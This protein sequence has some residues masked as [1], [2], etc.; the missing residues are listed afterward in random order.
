MAAALGQWTVTTYFGSNHV[1][2]TRRLASLLLGTMAGQ[3]SRPDPL[4]AAL[5]RPGGIPLGNFY[6]FLTSADVA[7]LTQ[8]PREEVPG[9]AIHDHVLFD[10]DFRAP[11]NQQKTLPLGNILQNGRNTHNTFNIGLDALTKHVVVIGVTGSGKTTTVMNLLDRV[12]E[13]GRPFLVIEPAKTEY[14]A[15]RAALADRINLRIYTLGSEMVAPFRLNPF[16]FQTDD[17]PGAV[18][19]LSHIDFLK[20]VFNAAFESW[21]PLPQVLEEAMHEIYEDKGWD[22]ASGTNRRVPDWS[23]RHDYPIF[24]SMTDLYYK[25]QIVADR[26]GYKGEVEGNVKAALKARIGSLRIGSKGLMLD[27][28]RG[29]PM[30]ELLAH[31]TILELENIG[32]DD[33]KTFIMGIL[34]ARLYEF[35]R[36]EAARV[37]SGHLSSGMRHLLV[38]EEAHR[39][40]KNTNTQVATDS[41]NPRAQAIEVFTNMLSEVRAY[42]QGVL[43][44]EQIPS[45][46]APDVL[47]NTN[48]KIVHRLIAQDDRQ[49]IGQTMNL[50]EAQQMH[51]GILEPGMAEVYAEGADH[52]YL[53]RMEN[54]KRR[55]APLTDNELKQISREYASTRPY[56]LILEMHEYDLPKSANGDIDPTV[57]LIA[58][59]LLTFEMSRRIWARL[60]FCLVMRPTNVPGLLH[61]CS[62][63]I[64]EEMSYLTPEQHDAILRM[65][66]VRGCAEVLHERGSRF[67]WT[68]SQVE[69]LRLPLTRGLLGLAY[70]EELKRAN[71]ESKRDEMLKVLDKSAE[72]LM[73]FVN[74]YTTFMERRQGPFPGCIHCPVKCLYRSEVSS[75]LMPKDRQWIN[76]ELNSQAHKGSKERYGAVAQAARHIAQT[77]LGEE[78]GSTPGFGVSSIAYCTVLHTARFFQ[79]T[80]Y[81]QGMVGDSLKPFLLDE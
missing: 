58:G 28:A 8:L 29:V 65:L 78:L 43:V 6:S 64:E 63:M 48:L 31:P 46:L 54:Y 35:R 70:V 16:E 7:V 71:D 3:D 52:A 32:N 38:F 33:E 59:R 4:R 15:L 1:D 41:A 23:K 68:Y 80:E 22:L 30:A 26:L 60:L 51:L 40:L 49:S 14:R 56:Q 74:D 53:V 62:E 44:A 13:A 10:V 18:S 79:L 17:E 50:N 75:L 11:T 39:L 2:D 72:N 5:C 77:W 36:L 47:K 57:Y 45:K 20:A 66:I 24:P 69:R 55:L 67:G 34:L 21:A 37:T 9:Y 61:L 76:D 81:E 42:G 12:V 27:T 25:A 73:Q 19:L